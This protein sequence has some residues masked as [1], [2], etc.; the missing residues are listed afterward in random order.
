LNLRSSGLERSLSFSRRNGGTSSHYCTKV[1]LE[2]QRLSHWLTPTFSARCLSESATTVPPHATTSPLTK[3]EKVSIHSLVRARNTVESRSR[4]KPHEA[5]RSP[6]HS[7]DASRYADTT[8]ER[9]QTNKTPRKALFLSSPIRMPP[10]LVKLFSPG[11]SQGPRGTRKSSGAHAHAST[12]ARRAA[13]GVHVRSG[14]AP[15]PPP[16]RGPVGDPLGSL[17]LTSPLL[18]ATC[19]VVPSRDAEVR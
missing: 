2:R 14:A 17:N 7:A 12:P 5:C 9:A 4:P 6:A 8:S 16:A 18:D 3:T 1:R 11:P 15:P 13:P 19:R 10:R